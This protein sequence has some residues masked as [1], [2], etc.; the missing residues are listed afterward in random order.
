MVWK[1]QLI[2]TYFQIVTFEIRTHQED[3]DI[4]GKCWPTNTNAEVLKIRAN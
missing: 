2:K 3:I 1:D 4:N